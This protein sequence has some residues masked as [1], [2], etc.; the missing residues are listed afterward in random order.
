MSKI[1]LMLKNK[2]IV[3]AI[4]LFIIII[5]IFIVLNKNKTLTTEQ[6]GRK[7]PLIDMNNMSN[8]KLINGEKVNTSRELTKDKEIDKL[9]FTNIKLQTEKG[10]SIFTA[11][12]ENTSNED[13]AGGKITLRFVDNEDGDIAKVEAVLPPTQAGKQSKLNAST[14]QDVV[15]AGNVILEF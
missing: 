7:A 13:F 1:L 5:C 6:M 11:T 8:A 15:N 14:M 2:K 10:I 4:A 3:I 12:V 9:I